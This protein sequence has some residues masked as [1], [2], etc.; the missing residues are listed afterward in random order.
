M[1][2]TR[3]RHQ[4]TET[5]EIADAIDA[6]LREWPDL[7]R[8]DVI[9]ELI[10]KG[11]DSLSLSATE[12]VLAMELALKELASLDIHYPKDYLEDLRKGWDRYD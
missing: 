6:G 4:I 1:P 12:R 8:S 10:V 5:D 9:R 3:P 2:T 11:A 7:N